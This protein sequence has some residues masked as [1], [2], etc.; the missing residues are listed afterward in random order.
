MMIPAT[1]AAVAALM[2]ALALAGGP[3]GALRLGWPIALLLVPP[4]VAVPAGGIVLDARLA[5]GA[6]ALLGLAMHGGASAWRRAWGRWLLSDLIIVLIV[7]SHAITAYT[8][9]ELTPSAVPSFLIRWALPYLV[10]RVFLGSSDDV[11]GALTPIGLCL[12]VLAAYGVVEAATGINPVRRLFGVSSPLVDEGAGRF[13]LRRAVGPFAHS[14][15]FG[16]AQALALPWALEA[17]RRGRVGDGPRWWRVLP[18]A[19]LAGIGSSLSRA[20]LLSGL[21]T[22]YVAAF[23]AHRRWRVALVLIACAAAAAVYVGRDSAIQALLRAG[24]E[25]QEEATTIVVNGEVRTYTGTFHRL[26]LFE[27]YADT[28]AQAGLFG[29]GMRQTGA[30]LA[31]EETGLFWSVDCHYI[32]LTI[33]YGRAA[34]ALFLA[35]AALS[36]YQLGRV[37]WPGRSPDAPLAGALFGALL[38]VDAALLT[39]WM[40]PDF[41]A[42]WLFTAGVAGNLRARATGGDARA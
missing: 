22:C 4:W 28:M 24:G 27:V 19:T 17:A 18:W 35:L 2:A 3:R 10:G 37:A 5:A 7:T 41:G 29:F 36:L 42:L 30:D 40:A 34:L 1:L 14:I 15:Y 39:V 25:S 31:E 21:V 11:R 23:F 8:V 26:I 16:L 12:L 32:L 38:G 33:T 13:G 20:A 9:G 6:A